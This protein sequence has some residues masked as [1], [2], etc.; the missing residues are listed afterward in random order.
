MTRDGGDRGVEMTLIFLLNLFKTSG[1]TEAG[2]LGIETLRTAAS[3]ET[4][5]GRVAVLLRRE[6]S[7][8]HG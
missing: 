6:S 7:R 3:T 8:D 4:G 2:G 5:M 1:G